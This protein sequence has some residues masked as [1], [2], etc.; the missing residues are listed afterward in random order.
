[1]GAPV[2]ENHD[3]KVADLAVAK[4][5]R[6]EIRL[7]GHEMPGLQAIRQEFGAAQPL[8]GAKITG[9]L[10]MTI[11]TAVL[12]RPG[13]LGGSE[14][15]GGCRVMPAQREWPGELRERA[16]Q[17]V[18]DVRG[19]RARAGARSPGWAGGWVFVPRRCGRGSFF[20]CSSR[21]WRADGSRRVSSFSNMRRPGIPAPNRPDPEPVPV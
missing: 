13:D 11:Q 20:I 10:H 17:M 16:V 2:Q 1:M 19:G 12:D 5:G 21:T 18:L 6:K 14:F 8:Q 15:L 4:F 3:F 9:S 7:A